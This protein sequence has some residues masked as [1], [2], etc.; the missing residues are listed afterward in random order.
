MFVCG[1]VFLLFRRLCAPVKT[2]PKL[3]TRI[4]IGAAL[5]RCFCTGHAAG[6]VLPSL[7][8]QWELSLDT[9]HHKHTGK[10]AAFDG[11]CRPL[12]GL[13]AATRADLESAHHWRPRELP[14]G[15]SQTVLRSR[16]S[17]PR[18]GQTGQGEG[19]QV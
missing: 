3:A 5:P 1:V 7:D 4:S 18:S 2:P 8:Y 16:P 14:A 19:G 15:G 11:Q 17:L 13:P 12:V 10:T 9:G 6:L